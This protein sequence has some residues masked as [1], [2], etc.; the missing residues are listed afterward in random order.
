[1]SNLK[2]NKVI[3][4]LT[5]S[6]ILILSGWGLINPILAVFFSDQIVGGSLAVAGLASTIYFIVKS[7]VQI[8]IARLIDAKRGEWDDFWIM[9]I[10]SL[11]ISVSGFLFIFATT[12]IHVYLIQIVNGLGGALSYP[13]WLAIFT[14]HI[15]KRS[16]G[17]EWSLYYTA[18]DLG[19][20]LSAGLGGYLATNLG[21]R[22]MF[23]IVGTL[24][25]FGTLLLAGITHHLKRGSR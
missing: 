21:Y 7:F 25:L 11:L 24:S 5:Y 8:P 13:G 1:M 18:T 22:P 17:F 4:F 16:E 14:R 10:G 15:D 2:I 12:P 9:T 3:R 19:A 6:D 23:A 20:A